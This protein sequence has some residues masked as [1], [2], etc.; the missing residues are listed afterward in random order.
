MYLIAR[1]NRKSQL[2]KEE[3]IDLERASDFEPD[4]ARERERIQRQDFNGLLRVVNMRKEYNQLQTKTCLCC[5]KKKIN[6]TQSD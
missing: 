5:S 4:V 6:K 1:F 2:I 3:T